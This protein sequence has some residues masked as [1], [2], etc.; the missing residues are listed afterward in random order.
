MEQSAEAPDYVKQLEEQYDA[1]PPLA[2]APE[3]LDGDRADEL[4]SSADLIGDLEQFLRERREQ[5]D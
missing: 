3:T 5:D 1:N 4:P 2:G